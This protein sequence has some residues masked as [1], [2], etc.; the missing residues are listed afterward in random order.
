MGTERR[1]RE[2]EE[3]G[4]SRRWPR[5]CGSKVQRSPDCPGKD[6][7]QGSPLL[8]HMLHTDMQVS[9]RLSITTPYPHAE[10]WVDSHGLEHTE[11]SRPAVCLHTHMALSGLGVAGCGQS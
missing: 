2:G 9:A 6:A 11:R 5:P 1:G 10:R 8:R 3:E 7:H 4:L